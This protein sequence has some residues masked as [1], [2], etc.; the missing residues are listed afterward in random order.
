MRDKYREG[1]KLFGNPLTHP[2]NLILI[3]NCLVFILQYFAGQLLIFRFALIPDFVLSGAYWQ[4]FTYGFLHDTSSYFPFHLLLNMYGFY[5]LGTYVIPALGKLKFTLLYFG[6]QLGGGL[7]V[8][9]S[10]FINTQLGGDIPLLDNPSAPTIGASGGVFGL[11]AVFGL[12]YPNSELFL[13]VFR[14]KA[15]NAVWVSLLVGYAIGFLG[16]SSISNTC[17]LGG[18]IAGILIFR[19][20]EK[21]IRSASLPTLPGMDWDREDEPVRQKPKSILPKAEDLFS[22]QKKANETILRELSKL[23]SFEQIEDYLHDKQVVN[24]NICP[25]STYNSED[26]ICLRCEWLPNCALRKAKG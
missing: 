14:V 21:R 23:A 12:L 3:F 17:H 9:F 19:L 4:L 5:M 18:A 1:T 6:A 22:D 7:F 10:A 25:P 13:L 8:L 26:P 16:N 15:K 24:A 2:L 20:M 11:L